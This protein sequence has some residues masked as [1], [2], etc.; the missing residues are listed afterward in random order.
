MLKC[1]EATSLVNLDIG[2]RAPGASDDEKTLMNNGTL[3]VINH[4][5]VSQDTMTMMNGLWRS[6]L[7]NRLLFLNISNKFW[8]EQA[9]ANRVKASESFF[10]LGVNCVNLRALHA[11]GLEFPRDAQTGSYTPGSVPFFPSLEELDLSY[12]MLPN[13]NDNNPTHNVRFFFQLLIENKSPVPLKKLLLIQPLIFENRLLDLVSRFQFIE[14]LDISATKVTNEGLER[15]VSSC[16]FKNTLRIFR[17]QRFGE[18]DAP[19]QSTLPL[20][21]AGSKLLHDILVPHLPSFPKL[22]FVDWRSV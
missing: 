22:K 13:D 11:R 20:H 1:L 6:G 5:S 7:A 17:M 2:S 21:F 4:A 19:F 16:N 18:P 3:G 8:P 9:S 10:H 12:C 15:C 14:E